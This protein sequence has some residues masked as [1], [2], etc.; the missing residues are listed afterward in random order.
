MEE[1]LN[2][3]GLTEREAEEFIIYWL[4]KLES[5]EYNFIRFQ[6]LDEQNKNMPLYIT[7]KPQILIRVMMEYKN[8]DKPMQVKEQI[9]PQKQLRNGFTIVE[10]GGTKIDI[11]K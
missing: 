8:L 11:S 3:L 4:P 6:T 7:P 1:K 10:W 2:Q 9:L 5:A